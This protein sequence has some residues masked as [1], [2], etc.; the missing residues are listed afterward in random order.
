LTQAVVFDL[1]GVIVDSE[2]VWDDVRAQYVRERGGR[3]GVDATRAMMGM[4]SPEWSAY[5]AGELGV[6][7]TPEQINA[8]VV[9][10]MLARYG[11]APPLIDGAIAAVSQVAQHWPI[12]IASSSNVELIDVVL[13]AAGLTGIVRET[14]SSEQVARG[15]PAP[16]VYL[17]AALRLGVDPSVCAAVEDSHNGIRSAKAAGMYVYAIPNPHYPPGDDAVAD[18]DVVLA[19]ISELPDA[20]LGAA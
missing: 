12:A 4:S 18:A 14:V 15:K 11:S 10:R 6:P 9:E 5:M 17:E 7:G 3:Y 8:D 19:S 1:D 20:L 2:Q 13:V 16:D